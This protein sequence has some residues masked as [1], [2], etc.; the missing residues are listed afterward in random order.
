MLDS[1]DR[2][3]ISECRAE[4]WRL[5]EDDDLAAAMFLVLANKQDLSD[6]MPIQEIEEKLD[7]K[8]A[9]ERTI[10]KSQIERVVHLHICNQP[11]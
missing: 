9:V 5:L 11:P 10:C 3:R 2:D 6:A 4:L 8:K 1:S 7:I